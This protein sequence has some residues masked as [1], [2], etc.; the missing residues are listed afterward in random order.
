MQFLVYVTR[1]SNVYLIVVGR[2]PPLRLHESCLRGLY[3]TI[4]YM[5][6]LWFSLI[7]ESSRSVDDKLALFYHS[8]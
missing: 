4:P 8:T 2:P 5:M 7:N 3:E 1:H 6:L